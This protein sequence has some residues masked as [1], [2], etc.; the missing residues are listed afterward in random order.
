MDQWNRREPRNKSKNLQPTDFLTKCQGHRKEEKTVSSINGT[1][2][3][4]YPHVE[5]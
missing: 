3:T 2:K 4:G 1:E 5:E